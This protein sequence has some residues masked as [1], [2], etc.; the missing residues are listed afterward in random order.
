MNADGSPRLCIVAS[1]VL[2]ISV[3]LAIVAP[4]PGAVVARQAT[5]EVAST[6]T[7]GGDGAIEITGLVDRPGPLTV[8]DLQRLPTETVDVTYESGEGSQA[9]TFTGVRLFAVLEQVGLTVGADERNPLL[10]RYLVL[11]AKDGYQVVLSGGELDPN[12]G[13]APILLAWEQDEQPLTGEDGPLR[14]VVPGD[15]RGGRYVY[16]IVRIEVLS[17]AGT[18]EAGG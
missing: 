18:P 9:H 5:P 1:I 17:I 14:L 4:A 3:G 12:F 7:A 2:V 8:A 16:G 13:N 15:K 10:L 11:S 6:A